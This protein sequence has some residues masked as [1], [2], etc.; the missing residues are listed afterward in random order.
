MKA[1]QNQCKD[2]CF[3]KQIKKAHFLYFIF[4][5][6]NLIKLEVTK[7]WNKDAHMVKAN[8]KLSCFTNRKINKSE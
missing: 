6:I 2:N 3:Q 8:L 1:L 4:L 5:I 7:L